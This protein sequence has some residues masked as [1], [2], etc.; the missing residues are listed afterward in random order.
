[1]D[2]R[3]LL[4]TASIALGATV[5]G[6]ACTSGSPADPAELPDADADQDLFV[7]AASF[8]LLLGTGRWL[9]FG[10]TDLQNSPLDPE[11]EVTVH[12]RRIATAPDETAEVIAG[13]LEAQHSP[14]ADTGQGVYYLQTDLEEPGIIDIVVQSG[15]SFGTAAVQIVDPSE[16]RVVNPADG[17]PVVPGAMAISAPTPTVEDDMGVFAICTQDPQCGMHEMSLDD[18]LASGR[19]VAVVFA[20]PQ[21]CQTVVCGPSVANLDTL[22]ET[23]EWGDTIFVHSEIFAEEPSGTDVSDTP[24]VP[25]VQAWGLPTEPWLF[26][27]GPDGVIIDRLDGP[28]P[29]PILSALLSQL[30]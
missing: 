29:Q 23:G 27:I 19:P 28:M 2:R 18:A 12:L 9:A 30:A 22:R 20:T 16:S 3:H 25:A 7:Q 17:S 6:S 26:T 11:A 13:P 24:L 1:M 21:F 4:Q 8:E 14:A 10:V 5:L 15:G